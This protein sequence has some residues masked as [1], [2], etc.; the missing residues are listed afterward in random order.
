MKQYHINTFVSQDCPGNPTGV[1]LCTT[2]P[3]QHEMLAIARH[4]G[5]HESVFV[6]PTQAG[7]TIRF[8]TLQKEIPFCLHA[9]LA[10]ACALHK[11][12]TPEIAFETTDGAYTVHCHDAYYGIDEPLLPLKNIPV[13]PDLI[14]L[15][16][17]LPK[18][19]F[20]GR[21]LMLV[22]DTDITRFQ[23]N[24]EKLLTM[25]GLGVLI[26][27]LPAKNVDPCLL[28]KA[29]ILL[30]SP[31][32]L[33]ESDPHSNPQKTLTYTAPIDA[34]VDPLAPPA[35]DPYSALPCHSDFVSRCFFPKLKVLEDSA[36]GSA[37]RM[38][39][40][41]WTKKLSKHRLYCKQLGHPS[42]YLLCKQ[43]GP[44]LEIGGFCQKNEHSPF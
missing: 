44:T 14:D 40:P 29:S 39:A 10:A 33:S 25:P 21:D 11:T 15:F 9:L 3:D 6:C 43:E 23:P 41:Y 22:F 8:F 7:Y 18:K 35:S 31:Q 20:L 28:E 27:A 13:T 26:T 2:F 38:L 4:F 24:S 34:Q 42:G 36:T 19:A 32:S 12:S 5:Y 37:L 30:C 16:G 17:H 1:T